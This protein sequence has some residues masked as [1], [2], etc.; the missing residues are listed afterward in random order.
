VTRKLSIYL[1]FL[2]SPLGLAAQ[3]I[4][5]VIEY[6]PAPGQFINSSPWGTPGSPASLQ[7]GVNGSLSLGAFGGFVVFRFEEAVENHPDNPFGVDFTI[8]GN[9][10]SE[11]SEPGVVW[12]MKDENRN[13][14]PDDTWYELAGSDYHFSTTL[15]EYEVFYTNPG[16]D[17]ARDVPW[18]DSFGNSGLIKA[19]S[20]HTQP[21]YPRTDSFPEVA[22]ESYALSGT[23]IQGAVDVNHPPL[24]KSLIRGFGY[25]D[26]RIRGSGPHTLPDNPYTPEVENSGGDAFDIDW[27]V[28]SD[29]AYVDLDRIHFVK[30]QNGVLHE[31]G[32]LGE[33]STEITGAI[34]VPA[35]NSISGRLGQLVIQDLPA[36]VDTGS[37][38]LELFMFQMGRPVSLP[39]IQWTS[40]QEWAMVDETN[41]LFI[42]G[43]GQL[44]LTAVVEGDP[45]LR[46]TVS[47]LVIPE[48]PVGFAYEGFEAGPTLYPNPA[49]DL[50]H[51]SGLE[52]INLQIYESSGR[53][54]RLIE[55]YNAGDAINIQELS[56]GLYLVRIEEA[57]SASYLKLLKQ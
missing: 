29:G 4:S 32:W 50:I 9:A 46:A 34:D 13:N 2:L 6:V 33:L 42:S 22:I 39:Q 28:N 24:I 55:N 3:Y 10:S 47:T 41:T 18:S 36:E 45:T 56:P 31:G 7:G 17:E 25:A 1:I 40:N 35:D 37:I 48:V 5:E 19:N 8:F 20:A 16:G 26:N 14:L 30:V 51:I 23:L 44:T 43:S 27:A 54:I 11:W 52:Q 38:Q 49:R 12:V 15:R 53:M 21:Y 57:S